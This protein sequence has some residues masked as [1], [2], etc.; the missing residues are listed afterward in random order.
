MRLA[1]RKAIDFEAIT[2]A[3]FQNAIGA[4]LAIPAYGPVTPEF[5]GYNPDA[6]MQEYEFNP[7]K[8]MEL[9]EAAG[10]AKG[11]DGVYQRTDS[12]L[13]WPSK[14]RQTTPNRMKNG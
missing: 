7:Q 3:V 13:L 9:L 1:I 11:S 10:F 8:A 14:H 5:L 12:A 6:W 2:N 4:T